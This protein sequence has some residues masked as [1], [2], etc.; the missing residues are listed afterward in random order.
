MFR[1]LRRKPSKTPSEPAVPTD[2][3]EDHIVEVV[4]ERHNVTSPTL[5]SIYLSPSERN[6]YLAS[7]AGLDKPTSTL[8]LWSEPAPKIPELDFPTP[9]PTPIL[10]AVPSPQPRRP[11]LSGITPVSFGPRGHALLTLSGN[12][13]LRF[14]GFNKETILA[15]E[16][17]LSTWHLGVEGRSRLPEDGG[18]WRIVLK[19][20][21]WRV[22]GNKELPYVFDP[23]R[24][25]TLERSKCSWGSSLC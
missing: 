4:P 6:L 15:A 8:P 11:R 7:L 10:P 22:K 13:E 24:K 5:Q 21:V 18:V 19:G 23:G 20:R 14:V 25:L 3:E 16:K 12:G 9:I 17:H 1:W 2:I